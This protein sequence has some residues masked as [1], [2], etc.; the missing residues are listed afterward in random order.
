MTNKSRCYGICDCTYY[1]ECVYLDEIFA[2]KPKSLNVF[3]GSVLYY[4]AQVNINAFSRVFFFGIH[5]NS[6]T[7]NS[8][9]LCGLC[10]PF[11][12]TRFLFDFSFLPENFF[13]I[14]LSLRY[15]KTRWGSRS[16]CKLNI[17]VFILMVSKLY[18]IQVVLDRVDLGNL[19]LVT[20]AT[21]AQLTNYAKE[22]TPGTLSPRF[23]S[24]LF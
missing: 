11:D 16:C 5:I 24:T 3:L 8:S 10:F 6:P 15:V 22:S 13:Q 12:F 17:G 4:S 7:K 20:S 14:Q 9:N 2:I 23:S 21:P 18:F 19:R 1:E